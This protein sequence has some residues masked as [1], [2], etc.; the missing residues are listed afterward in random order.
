MPELDNKLRAYAMR[1]AR[2]AHHHV[3]DVDDLYQA[4]YVALLSGGGISRAWGNMVW[5]L[6]KMQRD[7][8]HAH[9]RAAS[10]LPL[11]AIAAMP[12]QTPAPEFAA[13]ISQCFDRL[14]GTW[15]EICRAKMA[16]YSH[17]EISEQTHLS[18]GT[19]NQYWHRIQ[20]ILSQ[21]VS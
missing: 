11:E 19:V 5:E 17:Q 15:R 10:F 1:L 3:V 12:S 16:G 7:L 21:E 4:G 14:P 8:R 2:H 20:K 18:L 13:S 6:R 9:E